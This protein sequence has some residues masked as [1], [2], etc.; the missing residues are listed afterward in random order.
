MNLSIANQTGEEENTIM[1]VV[2]EWLV[3]EIK[4][5]K[6]D[7]YITLS[8]ERLNLAVISEQIFKKQNRI[9]LYQYCAPAS[10]YVDREVPE[11]SCTDNTVSERSHGLAIGDNPGAP[12]QSKKANMTKK[13]YLHSF[14]E[15][16]NKKRKEKNSR[17]ILVLLPF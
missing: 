3:V 10:N 6:C 14:T 9:L 16:K 12:F 8:V 13:N 15:T 1:N 17:K 11:Q 4:K 2:D 5:K 7:M